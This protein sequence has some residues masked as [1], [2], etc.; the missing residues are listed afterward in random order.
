MKSAKCRLLTLALLFVLTCA[1][2][3]A[4]A[5]SELTGIVTDQSGAVVAGAQVEL[6]D[7]ATGIVR[8]T[9]SSTSGLYEIGALNAGSYNL[10]VTSPGFQTFLQTGIVIDI[11]RTFRSD[12]R[13]V[14]GSETQTVTVAA[15]SLR[16]QSDSNVISSVINQE[17]VGQISTENRN[18]V[19][20]VVLALGASANIP[21][22]NTPT[23]VAASF[24]IS[25]NGLQR[26]HN[27]YMIDGGE[28]DDRGG[29]GSTAS[30]PSQDALSEFQVL[31]SNYPPDYGIASGA[32]VTMS[33][34][35]GTR[36]F[37]GELFEENRNTDYDANQY[38][39]KESTP[40]TPRSAVHY[41]IFGGNLG[42]PAMIPRLY[43]TDRKK[44]FFFWSEEWREIATGNGT[45][46]EPTL[47]PA[48]IPTAGQNLTYVSPKFQSPA[49]Q[50]IVPV[51]AD[52]SPTGF[53]AKL[54]SLGLT[55]GQPFPNN[56]IPY[57]LFDPNAVLY[58][59]LGIIPKPN[60][61]DDFTISNP[62]NT[63]KVRDDIVKGNH[64]FNDKWELMGHFIHDTVTQGYQTP[65]AGW[66]TASY[67]TVSSTLIT[68]S[69]AGSLKLT[70]SI[71]PDLLVEGGIYYD[72]NQLN[73]ANTSGTKPAGWSV[74]P[75]FNNGNPSLPGIVGFGTPYGTA[76][77]MG[78]VPWH[79]AGGDFDE[80]VDLSYTRA[81]HAMK[82]G[83]GF[84]HYIKNQQLGDDAE[85]LYSF[86]S[87]SHDGIMDMLMG[88]AASYNQIQEAYI[89]HYVNHTP[90]IYGMDNWHITPR[91]SIQYGLRYDALVLNFERGN[92]ASNF[93]PEDYMPTKVPEW[94]PDGSMNANGPG[95]L[96][97]KGQP[98]YMN[99]MVIA[100]QNGIPKS[101]V[102]SDYDTLEPRAGFSYDLFGNGK[103]VLRGGTGV[104]YERLTGNMI[105]NPA[106][107]PPFANYPGANNVYFSNPSRSWVTGLT[108]AAPVFPE[109]LASIAA[110][111]KAPA[112][113]QF[114][115]GVQHELSP[116]VIWV[117]QYV[118]NLAWHHSIITNINNF[119]LSTSN[120]I[121]C[122]DGDPSNQYPG[123]TCGSPLA[124][125]NIYRTYQ[126]YSA[127]NPEEENTNANYNGL[128]TAVR[129][130]NRW[131]LSGEFDYVWSHE[132][133]IGS[134][135]YVTIDN[136]YN[137]KYDKG[138][139][140]LDRR[141]I[142][143]SNYV[144]N[145]PFFSK[146][147]GLTH[148]LAGG[149][150]LAGTFIDETGLV[151]PPYMS[152]PYDPIGLGGN[153]S[154]GGYANHPNV[155][156]KVQYFK[157]Q[158]KWFNISQFSAPIPAWLGGPN[159]GFG[160]AGK[161]SIVT[162]GRVNFTTSLY[163][164][165]AFNERM[166]FDLRFESFNTF[167]HGE[168]NGV[169]STLG[170]GNFG[171]VNTAWDARALQLGGKFVF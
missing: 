42:G 54:K 162:P 167:N 119:P 158:N 33:I 25:V 67:N 56:T 3:C 110:P 104:F 124:N 83:A 159:L 109:F 165:F 84:N 35:S 22:S 27:L 87:L 142:F 79:N 136:P 51:V 149:W 47:D 125:P 29:G 92:N 161:D 72:G 121:L 118:G 144:Y 111:D 39:N 168:L 99:G 49:V 98:Y 65:Q 20:L 70:G 9:V 134:A 153:L 89:Y 18:L 160:N 78:N 143:N 152:I 8:S 31:A 113:D 96:T 107:D 7:P 4:Q 44:T 169:S 130:Q 112:V 64:K 137:I 122:D 126:G 14:I 139:G 135:E 19:S 5:N 105:T 81:Q 131:G 48:D 15:D 63:V 11:S 6:T 32:I 66:A 41:N 86:E 50:L 91:L 10:K 166:H 52:P 28:S 45:N 101:L 94:N 155:I 1:G 55:P 61:S 24:N 133:D 37:H 77:D 36:Q 163:K 145:T 132:I 164:S 73:F 17:Q 103:T 68:P 100:G 40:I 60:T 108:A 30:M 156:G 88:L 93:V 21:D 114:S 127:I 95:F 80:R 138:S 116:S 13:L 171:Q 46:V 128:Q 90:S 38:F 82:F 76:E 148:T 102:T 59:N 69:A 154:T 146:A 2:A 115:L 151:S 85:G 58:L 123:D 43:N 117:V 62:G 97:F 74:T 34:K 170:T 71:R 147:H 57:Q 106:S 16:V 140:L 157:Q 12:V 75:F 120:A 129:I 150:S 141:Q 23:S 53:N 26:D